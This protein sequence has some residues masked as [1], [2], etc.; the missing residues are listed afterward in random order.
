MYINAEQITGKIIIKQNG[1]SLGYQILQMDGIHRLEID[2]R[3]VILML[4]RK[5]KVYLPEIESPK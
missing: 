2:S 3:K 4:F 1:R 5:G